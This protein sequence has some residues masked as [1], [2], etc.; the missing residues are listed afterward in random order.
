[1]S[2]S[3]NTHTQLNVRNCTLCNP[4]LNI[5]LLSKKEKCSAYDT[6]YSVPWDNSDSLGPQWPIMNSMLWGRQ[7]DHIEVSD[8]L[9]VIGDYIVI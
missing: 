8:S 4:H 1:M 9:E 3:G 2:K 6:F 5:L 7:F